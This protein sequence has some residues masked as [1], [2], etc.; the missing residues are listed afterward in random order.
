[1]R[2]TQ[3]IKIVE[4]KAIVERE[5]LLYP[6]GFKGGSLTELWQV[7]VQLKSANHTA[8]GYGV[9]SVLWSD[10]DVFYH[11][12]EE[13]GNKLMFQTTQ[14]ALD[15]LINH[16]YLSPMTL[17]DDIFETV[18]DYAKKITNN[19]QLRKTFVLNA[20]T[21][22]DHAA[23]L[24]YAYENGIDNFEKMIPPSYRTLLS[25]KN[26]KLAALPALSYGMQESLI[27]KLMKQGY[28]FLKIKIGHPGADEEMLAKDKDWMT[29]IHRLASEFRTPH[30]PDGRVRYYL[31]ANGRYVEKVQLKSFIGHLETIN[32]LDQVVLL[33]EPF[34]EDSE[35]DVSDFG[36][37]I[38]M[39]E[40]AHSEKEV[41]SGIQQGY[42]AIALKPTAKT[43]SVTLKMLN[44]A[45]DHDIACF[46]ADLTASP[47]LVEWNK[48]IAA[49]LQPFPGLSF[50]FLETNGAQ[51]YKNWKEL[52]RRIPGGKIPTDHVEG[53]VFD[54]DESF[55]KSDESIFVPPF[56][57][58]SFF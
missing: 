20:L 40:S 57:Y 16:E 53:G 2:K 12:S 49:R 52:C 44:I 42:H 39:D 50:N 6:F 56:H 35:I 15:L 21:P 1:M 13:D 30:T 54:L 34:P 46:C 38:A 5:P 25:A 4:A 23:W 58:K 55:Y 11:H 19:T 27:K 3:S 14:M 8:F 32:A 22:I 26:D 48:R 24:L 31:D 7:T 10:P 29:F 18:Y 9:Q 36:L 17:L 37:R 33:E 45:R 41:L 28:F 43:L 51:N 47:M